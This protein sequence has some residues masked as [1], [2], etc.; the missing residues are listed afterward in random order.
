MNLSNS[1]L[2]D[3]RQSVGLSIDMSDFDVDLLLH[4][5]A[6]IG[7]LNQNGVGKDLI[8]TDA[9]STWNDLK[10]PKQSD[11]NQY[12]KIVPLF[13]MLSTK[14]LF[15]PPPPSSVQVYQDQIDQILWR[16]KIAYETQIRPQHLM[17]I[18]G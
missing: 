17:D 10:D 1:I 16:L 4:I 2:R 11:G 5:N 3:I 12:F 13:L 15:D 8:V 6:A 9:S 7:T 14:V 18:G